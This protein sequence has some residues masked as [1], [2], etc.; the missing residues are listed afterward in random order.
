[1]SRTRQRQ[2]HSKPRPIAYEPTEHKPT[3]HALRGKALGGKVLRERGSIT[4]MA[5]IL[6]G[7]A[8]T[9]L[10]LV[11]DGGR[12]MAARRQADDVAT[13]AA[14]A[15]TQG[16]N[17]AVLH[18]SDI[19]SIDP[20]DAAARAAQIASPEGMTIAV[21]VAGDRVIVVTSKQIDLPMLGLLGIPSRTVQGR[22]EARAA[23]GLVTAP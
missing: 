12:L 21:T 16:V 10:A 22:G 17:E 1:M 11:I 5:V 13:Q 14:I 9:M 4:V 3:E 18:E 15:G 6:F 2:R 20:N 8:I 19:V 23:P 7:C